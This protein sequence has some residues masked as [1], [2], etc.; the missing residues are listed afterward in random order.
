MVLY[1]IA[2]ELWGMKRAYERRQ[3]DSNA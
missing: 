3:P 2:G 1:D